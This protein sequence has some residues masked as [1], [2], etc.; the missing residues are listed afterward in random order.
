MVS[1]DDTFLEMADTVAKRSK[2]PSTK[3]GA[4]LVSPDRR[5]IAVGYNGFPSSVYDNSGVLK[6]EYGWVS[7]PD[8]VLTVPIEDAVINK[9]DIII[10]AEAN[11]IA[12]CHVRPV[13][14]T[15][16]CTHVPCP[17]CAKTI[18][19]NGISRVVCYDKKLNGSNI[20]EY[21]KN[22]IKTLTIFDIASIK[23]AI[24]GINVQQI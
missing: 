5:Q 1:W 14:W 21:T 6:K 3:V 8:R 15:I 13:N 12:N 7:E 4:V 19:A 11:A 18:A 22:K 10:H 20:D 17:E 16:Y 2:D 9:Y 24:R 23:Y